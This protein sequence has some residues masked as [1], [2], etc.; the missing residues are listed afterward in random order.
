MAISISKKSKSNAEEEGKF[1][2][3]QRRGKLYLLGISFSLER[4]FLS[5]KKYTSVEDEKSGYILTAHI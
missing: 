1:Q 2:S 5:E 4:S 3:K